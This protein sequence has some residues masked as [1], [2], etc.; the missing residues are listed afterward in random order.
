MQ[1]LFKTWVSKGLA[2][3]DSEMVEPPPEGL[4][5]ASDPKRDVRMVHPI[6]GA[7]AFPHETDLDA[8][9]RNGWTPD[10]DD[11]ANF[12]ESVHIQAYYFQ[13]RF[14][15]RFRWFTLLRPEGE[16]FVIADRAVGW[17]ADGYVNA[18]PSC[19]RDPSAF[20]LAP[21]S[22]SLVLVGRH[23]T[24]IWNV[25]PAQ[26][27]A[28][29]AC[30]AHEWIAGPTQG[31][32]EDALE[33]RADELWMRTHH[34]SADDQ[35]SCATAGE[36]IGDA[37]QQHQ[38]WLDFPS[39]SRRRKPASQPRMPVRKSS[40]GVLSSRLSQPESWTWS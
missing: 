17:S 26:V 6:L 15:P 7:R 34:R 10:Y 23:A 4:M 39:S 14:F 25:T 24:D 36:T 28:V 40:N 32:V 8:A 9:V 38:S 33:R 22:R 37:E 1:E 19:L 29:V 12:L 13:T 30:W 18:P 2:D 5:A 21:I 11:P 3:P 27:N 20:V 31:A 16:F 35:S